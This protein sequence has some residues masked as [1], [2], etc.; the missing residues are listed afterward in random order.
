M[1][2]NFSRSIVFLGAAL[3]LGACAS[4]SSDTASAEAPAPVILA[5]EQA[6]VRDLAS[7]LVDNRYVPGMSIGII[8][9][10]QWATVNLGVTEMGGD[11]PTNQTIYEIGSVSKALT[12]L[13]L[14][15]MIEQGE[16]SADDLVNTYLPE[17]AQLPASPDGGS[18]TLGHLASH[19]SGLPRLPAN[20]R[21]TNM[22]DP[23]ADWDEARLRASIPTM[24]YEAE[25]GQRYGY[26]NYAAGLLGY[27]LGRAAD[28]TYD[29]LLRSRVLR[30]A[31]M[32]DSGVALTDA[33]VEHLAAPYS[34]DVLPNHR[35]DLAMLAS[36][37][38]VHSTTADMLNLL[39]LLLDP[40]ETP[41]GRAMLRAETIVHPL[42]NSGGGVGLGW[43]R[44][45]G[46]SVVWHNGQTGGYHSYTAYDRS[47]GTAVV[48]LSNG[49]TPQVDAVGVAILDMLSD[50]PATPVMLPPLHPIDPS[51]LAQCEGRYQFAPGA[52]FE[53][54]ADEW[55]L[56]ATLTGQP[57]L[58]VYPESDELF[59][60][61][62]VD[63]TL[64]F[65]RNEA[66]DVESLTLNQSLPNGQLIDRTAPRIK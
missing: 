29:D 43:H 28:S 53:I 9:D 39:A 3:T 11:A 40:P 20:M 1:M 61:R 56:L 32:N 57:E 54:K 12:G 58:G 66:G 27:A 34:A 22:M 59:R 44:A 37:G 45:A 16:V 38:G 4:S 48:V 2:W 17:D 15:E 62:A 47:A 5:D 36:A 21:P 18:V 35:W 30:P 50:R 33:Q 64:R 13:L 42:D 49:A 23:Y 41:L 65:N 46:G 60:Y 19:T 10:G 14:A 6:S 24:P 55:R 31:S 63:A 7:P 8:K 51:V 26:S 25:P 52:V